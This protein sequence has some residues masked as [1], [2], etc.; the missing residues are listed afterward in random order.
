MTLGPVG[1]LGR[2]AAG[3]F[4]TVALVW[5]AITLALGF[6]APRV[7]HALSGAGWE[8][9]LADLKKYLEGPRERHIVIEA[10]LP[11]N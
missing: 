2:Y 4:R 8:A 5:A 10:G 9:S 3:H 1:R 11:Q 7:E 6:L